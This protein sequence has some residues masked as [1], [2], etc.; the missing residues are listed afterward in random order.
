MKKHGRAYKAIQEEVNN[1]SYSACKSKFNWIV[2]RMKNGKFPLDSEL[3]DRL[4]EEVT[5]VG[6]TQSSNPQ[7]STSKKTKTKKSKSK[8]M[9]EEDK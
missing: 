9:E 4:G 8:K 7:D 1:R 6:G 5:A 3:M 2:L